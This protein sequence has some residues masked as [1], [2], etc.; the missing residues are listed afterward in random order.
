MKVFAQ[1]ANM[2]NPFKVY[3]LRSC[4]ARTCCPTML[5]KNMQYVTEI[6]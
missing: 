1:Y 3:V 2:L 4:L 6:K 5:V